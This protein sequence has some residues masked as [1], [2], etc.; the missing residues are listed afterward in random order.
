MAVNVSAEALAKIHTKLSEAYKQATE[1]NEKNDEK[2]QKAIDISG[3][4]T[5]G[6]GI[7]RI[8]K[9]KTQAG[10]KKP[11]P[12]FD[13]FYS[14][15]FDAVNLAFTALEGGKYHSYAIMFG[16]L[17]GTI[18][19]TKATKNADGQKTTPRTPSKSTTATIPSSTPSNG[20]LTLPKIVSSSVSP[21]QQKTHKE[22]LDELL[23][24]CKTEPVDFIR[25][26]YDELQSALQ[27]VNEIYAERFVSQHTESS[28]DPQSQSVE[29]NI[30]K[31]DPTTRSFYDTIV[32]NTGY[33]Q[34]FD[35][36]LVDFKTDDGQ[37]TI[38]TTI[39][40]FS[41]EIISSATFT[42]NDFS[43]VTTVNGMEVKKNEEGGYVIPYPTT[44]V[45]EAAVLIPLLFNFNNEAVFHN[46][47]TIYQSTEFT[48]PLRVSDG[49]LITFDNPTA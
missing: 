17:Y 33:E 36:I 18:P 16:E 6:T 43:F 38:S 25:T 41:Y 12:G 42:P 46:V 44:G 5:T 14:D 7:K 39:P 32:A 37:L 4:L 15:N 31:M 26:L 30:A 28:A 20:K 3:L 8:P 9:P 11:V 45:A 10:S 21:V 22:Y 13:I 19:I 34:Y 24:K 2:G 49:S 48:D 23:E 35:D 1:I 29:E 27:T 40:K 47:D